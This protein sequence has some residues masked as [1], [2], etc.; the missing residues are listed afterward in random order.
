[1]VYG[2][3]VVVVQSIFTLCCVFEFAVSGRF[4]YGQF[5]SI[6]FFIHTM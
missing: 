2:G 3:F 6:Q 1:M 4:A 5:N